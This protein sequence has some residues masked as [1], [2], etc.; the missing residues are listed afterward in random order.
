MSHSSRVSSGEFYRTACFGKN[1]EQS[2]FFHNPEVPRLRAMGQVL[3][4]GGPLALRDLR[5]AP[6]AVREF[7][8]ELM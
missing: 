2:K 5:V 6:E 1:N 3:D 7:V 8:A 4:E